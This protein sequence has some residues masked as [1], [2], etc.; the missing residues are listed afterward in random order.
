MAEQVTYPTPVTVTFPNTGNGHIPTTGHEH[1]PGIDNGHI[2]A[3]AAAAVA[4]A[5]AWPDSIQVVG[6]VASVGAASVVED[7]AVTR[8]GAELAA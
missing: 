5:A 8:S 1:Y 7:S 6:A 3:A 4:A 2:P